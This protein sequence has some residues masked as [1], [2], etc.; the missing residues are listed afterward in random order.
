MVY[1]TWLLLCMLTATKD[2]A[3][4]VGN[5]VTLHHVC[6]VMSNLTLCMSY[7]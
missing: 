3:G 2:L 1:C 7:I 5:K 4:L 6:A